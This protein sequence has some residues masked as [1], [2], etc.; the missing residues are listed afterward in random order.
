MKFYWSDGGAHEVLVKETKDRSG[1]PLSSWGL[2]VLFVGSRG[3]PAAD[4][5]KYELFPQ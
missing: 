4:Y 1:K 3:M 2:G 5:G